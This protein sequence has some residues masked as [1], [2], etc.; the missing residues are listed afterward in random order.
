MESKLQP[1]HP[2]HVL[3]HPAT[4]ARCSHSHR[5][6]DSSLCKG[7]AQNPVL[8]LK[9]W[10]GQIKF[11]K[12][13]K[14]TC[15]KH[16]CAGWSK[17]KQTVFHRYFP[18]DSLLERCKWAVE[19]HGCLFSHAGVTLGLYESWKRRDIM[20]WIQRG[21]RVLRTTKRKHPVFL[22]SSKDRRWSHGA[23]WSGL[24]WCSWETFEPIP[25]IPQIVGHTLCKV[26]IV[27][28]NSVCL[29]TA[30]YNYGLLDSSGL[31]ILS[32]PDRFITQ[33]LDRNGGS[34]S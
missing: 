30:N 14:C 22:S 1:F 24:L 32:Y 2:S 28:G 27:K 29:D 15:Q 25:H 23:E 8:N 13:A 4:P 18:D 31:K 19:I 3:E 11:P 6:Y 21:E 16:G 10:V 9:P 17:E 34:L 33:S 12:W 26:P 5:S 7:Q 20:K